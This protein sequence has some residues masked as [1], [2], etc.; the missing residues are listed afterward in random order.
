MRHFLPLL[1]GLASLVISG[2]S[3]GRIQAEPELSKLEGKKIALVQLD[4]EP[5]ARAIV[6]VALVNQ[7]VARGSFI[8]LSEKDVMKARS[9]PEQ[10]P[11]DWLGIAK[12]A[13]A[14]FA[15]RLKVLEF[16]A[17][18]S[19]SYSAVEE[20][21]SQLAAERGD[22]KTERVIKQKT[23]EGAVR[24]QVD[25]ADTDPEAA[26]KH[27][28]AP[29]QTGIAEAK[30]RLSADS[31]TGAAHLPP[32]LGFLEKLTNEAFRKFFERYN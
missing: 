20:E 10:D 32:R 5:S 15:L 4:A 7:L 29:V 26:A 19:E 9:A 2:C 17:E 23:L 3:T 30:D 1:I 12:R 25:F 6:E 14:E 21:D 13:G 16:S 18:E 24:I 28:R 27:K 22:G 11:T 8:L 31:K